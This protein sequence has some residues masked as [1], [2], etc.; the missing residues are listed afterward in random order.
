MRG[1]ADDHSTTALYCC[2]Q[3]SSG[4]RLAWVG[5]S[6]ISLV[7]SAGRYLYIRDPSAYRLSDFISDQSI[8]ACL[9]PPDTQL[10]LG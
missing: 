8:A 10:P 6:L 7:Y 1:K 4:E 2:V 3:L 9:H 5:R